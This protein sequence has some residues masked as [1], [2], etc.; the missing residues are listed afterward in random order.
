[1][2]ANMT[3]VTNL[4][5]GRRVG[6]FVNGKTL[7]NDETI[8]EAIDGGYVVG[9]KEA[10]GQSAKGVLRGMVVGIQKDANGRKINEFLSLQPYLKGKVEDPTDNV[11]KENCAVRIVART[12]KEL[13][14]DIS[15]WSFFLENASVGSL[16]ITSISTGEE[17]NE[18]VL[19]EAIDLNGFGL[20]MGTGDSLKW[21]VLGESASG[22]VAQAKITSEWTR[23]TLASDVLDTIKTAAYD[24]K[25][26]AFEL[27]VGNQTVT[28]TALLRFVA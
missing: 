20:T 9:K 16:V 10:I 1:M 28:K 12:L 13:Q 27:K 15:D 4:L 6:R 2:A 5:N 25:T 21:S 18:I 24:G 19:G 23:I 7:T 14:P 22:T 17:V 3:V 8:Q 26:I 11:T